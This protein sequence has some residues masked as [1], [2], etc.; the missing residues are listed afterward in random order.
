MHVSKRTTRA[1]H[2]LLSPFSLS[3]FFQNWPWTP[4]VR[5]TPRPAHSVRSLSS[6]SIFFHKSCR[7]PDQKR[8]PICWM[9]CFLSLPKGV[10]DTRIK[11]YVEEMSWLALSLLRPP[12]Q[13][14]PENSDR[15]HLKLVSRFAVSPSILE[16][17]TETYIK[18]AAE[19]TPW[20]AL[21]SILSSKQ[22]H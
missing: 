22:L 10:L 5:N 2:G 13:N 16:R 17:V 9:D 1:L 20:S 7:Y 12:S 6:P 3:S 8:T 21:L 11:K 4:H 14:N 18:K 19:V 15:K